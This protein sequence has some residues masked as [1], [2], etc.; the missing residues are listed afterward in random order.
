M[1]HYAAGRIVGQHALDALRGFRRAVADDHHARVLR[2]AHAHAAAVVEA[3]PCRSAGAV[4]QRVE[5]RPVGN[6]VGAVLHG[7]GLAVGAGD[8]TGVEVVAADDDGRPE[9]AARHHLVEGEADLRAVAQADPADAGRQTLELDAALRHV[10]PV[11]QV[12]V[13]GQHFLHLR[14]GAIDVL[15]IAGER[16]PAERS[17][18]PAEQWPDVRGHEAGKIERIGHARLEGHL[19]DVVA[20]IHGGNAHAVEGQH[21]PHL[22]GHGRLGRSH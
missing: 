13:A 8:G 17:D 11:V 14:V 2:K 4:H 7:L 9:F 18:A 15:G 12:R 10:E 6:R 16:H 3:N 22:H 20:V 19:A 21:R 5:E 1:T